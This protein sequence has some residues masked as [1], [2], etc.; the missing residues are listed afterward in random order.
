MH[1]RRA[2]TA[3][4]FSSLLHEP[5]SKLNIALYGNEIIKA[6]ALFF[7]ARRDADLFVDEIDLKASFTGRRKDQIIKI[8]SDCVANRYDGCKLYILLYGLNW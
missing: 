8:S 3:A 6:M 2:C 7:S 1:E 4:K 5:R